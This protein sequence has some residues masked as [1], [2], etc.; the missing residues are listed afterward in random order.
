MGSLTK[1]KDSIKRLKQ[2]N[3]LDKRDLTT[4]PSANR[5]A[6]SKAVAELL[7]DSRLDRLPTRVLE[8]LALGLDRLADRKVIDSSK[9]ETIIY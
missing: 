9:S 1:F 7:S 4:L 2:L 6:L 3:I 5:S 8:N